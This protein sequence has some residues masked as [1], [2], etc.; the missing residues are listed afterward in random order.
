M[1]IVQVSGRLTKEVE[2]KTASTGRKYC[3]FSIAVKK[4]GAKRP[5]GD[6]DH[7]A[8]DFCNVT[9]FNNCAELMNVANKGD[10]ISV[11]GELSWYKNADQKFPIMTVNANEI[12]I[13]PKGLH[14]NGDA[15][16]NGG[17]SAPGNDNFLDGLENDGDYSTPFDL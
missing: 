14:N 5:N 16:N 6:V 13:Q 11:F 9:A 8:A 12:T 10:E 17:T 2:V 4:R 7:N 1:N 3:R 15:S